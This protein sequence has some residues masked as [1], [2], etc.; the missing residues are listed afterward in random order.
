[1]DFKHTIL[2]IILILSSTY[3]TTLIIDKKYSQPILEIK[4]RT[5]SNALVT[6]KKDN[7]SMDVQNIE[8]E[9]IQLPI[10]EKNLKKLKELNITLSKA[11][12]IGDD[13]VITFQKGTKITQAG[14]KI[15]EENVYL[16]LNNTPI[17]VMLTGHSDSMSSKQSSNLKLSVA[18]SLK[19]KK[20][21]V[22]LGI[23]PQQIQTQ[24]KGDSDP[25]DSENPLDSLNRRV[26]VTII[27]VD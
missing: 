15:L 18:R 4:E 10:A 5:N 1:M 8:E 16:V 13:F 12:K 19:V 23:N 3:I 17:K 6:D 26:H 11:V 25:I 7:S 27:S 21:L 9:N 2:I 22:E 20:E 14:R 24:G